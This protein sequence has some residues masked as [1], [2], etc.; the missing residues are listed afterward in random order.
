MAQVSFMDG[1]MSISAKIG[2]TIYRKTPSGK[3]IAYQQRNPR[4][5]P[6][7]EQELR[8]RK[9]FAIATQLARLVLNH[10]ELQ[11]TLMKTYKQI[12]IK[13]RPA[14]LRGYVL[15]QLMNMLKEIDL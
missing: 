2:D 6:P 8:H 3:T 7:T 10:P 1:I 11:K 4:T 12:N 15:S 9:R 13:K 5:S 14:T